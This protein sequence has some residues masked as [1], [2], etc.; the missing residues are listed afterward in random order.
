[1]I[2]PIDGWTSTLTDDGL[3]MTPP[4]GRACGEIRYREQLRPQRRAHDVVRGLAAPSGCRFGAP[5]PL[6][7]LL[8]REGEFAALVS[9][10][11]ER[12]GE[13]IERTVGIV[14]GDD[15]Y[16]VIDGVALRGEERDRFRHTVRALVAVDSYLLGERRRR[17]VHAPPPGWHGFAAGPMHVRWLPLDYPRNLGSITVYPALPVRGER[18]HDD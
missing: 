17:F 9:V 13:P 6:E 10:P 8:T 12:A 5:G 18:G 15:F 14:Y 2:E 4:E 3:R 7:P 11:G 16:S 1:M